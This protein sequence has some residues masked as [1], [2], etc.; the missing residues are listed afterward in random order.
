MITWKTSADPGPPRRVQWPR[1]RRPAP[2]RRS[3]SSRRRKSRSGPATRRTLH[4][5]PDRPVYGTAQGRLLTAA[6]YERRIVSLDV[7]AG[8]NVTRGLMARVVCVHGIAQQL[9][10]EQTLLRAWSPAI[11]DGV[12]RAGGRPVP[13]DDVAMAFYGDLFRPPGELLAVGDPFYGPEDVRPGFEQELLLAWWRHAATVDP[14]V[15]PPD[16]DTLVRVPRSVQKLRPDRPFLRVAVRPRLPGRRPCT[17][18][19][20]ETSHRPKAC[21]EGTGSVG[22]AVRRDAVHEMPLGEEEHDDH[23]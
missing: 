18:C 15:P 4:T 17:R 5:G 23:R 14:S 21:Y 11:T 3:I 22:P 1:N 9:R 2:A 12:I 13:A 20:M 19:R 6:E 10:G 7:A 8:L 16:A